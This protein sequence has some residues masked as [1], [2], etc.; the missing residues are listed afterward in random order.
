MQQ[1]SRPAQTDPLGT[2]LPRPERFPAASPEPAWTGRVTRGA[3]DGRWMGWRLRG[4]VL[5]TLAGSLCLFLVLRQWAAS[6]YVDATWRS[7]SGGG[8]ELLYSSDPRLKPLI[9]R[10]M[11]SL[12]APGQPPL[13]ADAAL[14]QHSPRWVVSDAHREQLLR[15]QQR[16][17]EL[18]QSPA[19]RMH[20]D[21]HAP[22]VLSPGARGFA[23]LG[24]QFWVLSALALVLYLIAAVVLLSRPAISNALYAVITL[25]QA[26]NL[27]LIALESLQGL[28]MPASMPSLLLPLR[29]CFDMLTVAAVVH[30]CA[31]HPVRVSSA[32]AFAGLGWAVALAFGVF[33]L[34]GS[35]A[36]Q[37]WM[38]QALLV[39]G[40]A[41]AIFVLGLAQRAQAHPFSVV[42]RRLGWAAT[43]TLALLTLAVGITSQSSETQYT[44]ATV[45]SVIWYVFFAALMLLVPFLPRSQQVMREFAMLA[46][47]STVA[48]SLDLLFVAL[49]ALGPFASLTLSLFLALG[50]Y[51]GARHWLMAQFTGS[52]PPSA[53]RMFESLYRVARDIEVDPAKADV[54]L[55]RLL[56][57]LFD[58]LETFS[59]SNRL[60]RPRVAANGSTLMV[61]LP[62]WPAETEASAEGMLVLRYARRGRHLF[63]AED[64]RL[65]QR[66]IEQLTRA[67]AYDRA[68]EQGR[69]EERMRLAQDLHDDIGAR[70][71]TMMY[72]AQN[73]EMEDYVRHTLQDLKT[74]TRGLAAPTHKLS[75]AAAEWKADAVQ[76]LDA[77]HC[78]LAWSFNI[79]DDINLGVV[80]WS[81]LTRVLRELTNNILSHAAATRVEIEGQFEAG[82]LT[83]KV[84]DDG[85]GR[86]PGI[87]AHGLGLGGVRKRVKLLGGEVRWRENNGRGITC[88]VRV[89]GLGE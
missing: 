87:W 39:G 12:D 57:E 60:A 14:T 42:L 80:Q 50:L 55:V 65:C 63:T 19:L 22:V 26:G 58:P 31:V 36:Y 54:H 3:I 5:L 4:L 29:V 69:R 66:L 83:L 27:L 37:W 68:V 11:R 2:T 38:T 88:E 30:V 23:G 82:H 81:A 86:E 1:P 17:S 25:S 18:V 10:V 8:L 84:S 75:H 32:W 73:P 64:A 44:I 79:D 34:A 16:L 40:G 74:L 53:E 71:L 62:T 21:F 45:G 20:F 51:I 43:T 77:A 35:L 49:F 78:E 56:Q 59:S 48:T 24:V 9:G 6:P 28:G 70:L 7:A 33:S 46:G 47:V 15:S 61:P 72:K 52:S 89:R 13:L 85:V 41:L 67:V 76:R